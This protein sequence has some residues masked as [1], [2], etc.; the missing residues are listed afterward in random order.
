MS[1]SETLDFGETLLG[2]RGSAAPRVDEGGLRPGER[3]GRYVVLSRLGAG[4]MGVVYAA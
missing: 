4:G 1:S 2:G 3:V